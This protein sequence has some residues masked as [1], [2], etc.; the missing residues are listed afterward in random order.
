MIKF[1]WYGHATLSLEVDGIRILVDPYLDANPVTTVTSD[2]VNPDV[3]LVSHG[4]GDHIGETIAIAKRTGAL[5]ISNH[6]IITWLRQQGLEKLHS[7]HIGG[8]YHHGFGYLK[9]TPAWHGSSLPDGSYGGTPCGFYLK[10]K[11]DKKIYLAQDTGLFSDMSLIGEG[12]LDLAVVPIG[13]NFT[14]GP[15]DALT[16]VRLLKP[17]WVVPIHYNTFELIRQD[18]YLWSSRVESST[19]SKVKVLTCGESFFF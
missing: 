18:P 4:H 6:E 9:L 5:V 8:G 16:A 19:S 11:D 17:D 14:M 7:Q 12:G 13:D 2:S 15:D 1:T 10:T 3:I